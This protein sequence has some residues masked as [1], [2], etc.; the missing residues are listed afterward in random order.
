MKNQLQQ[1]MNGDMSRRS[2]VGALA[3]MGIG[4]AA[5]ESVVRSAA[6]VAD[7]RPGGKG[8]QVTGTGGFVLVEQMAD[9]GVE[10]LFTNPGSFEVGLFDAF[11]GRQDMQIIVGLH[12]GLVIAMADGYHKVSGKPGFVNVHVVAGTAQAAGQMYNASRDRSSLIVTA[13]MIDNET[14]SDN[15]LLGARPGYDQKEINR[16]FTKIS[17]ESK[18]A[19]S[20]ALMLRRA[21]KV[22]TGRRGGQ[23]TARS[24]IASSRFG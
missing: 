5:A 24:R 17:W 13:G 7:G 2:F 22:A 19:A 15:V 9:A 10:Y 16:Q 20:I 21:F 11:L 6:A 23:E 8:R 18:N 3:A 4:V 14:F 12:E 1:F